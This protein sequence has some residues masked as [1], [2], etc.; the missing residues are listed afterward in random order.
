MKFG[1]IRA[2]L[3]DLDGTLIDSA[4]D[5]AWAADQL[6]L[7]RGLAPLPLAHYRPAVGS[8]A[9]GLIHAALGLGPEHPEF[10]DLKHAFFDTYQACMSQRTQAFEQV[11]EL[12]AALLQSGMAWA[13]VTNKIER[14]ALPLTAA[15]PLFASAS[16]VIGGDTTPHPKPH[17]A[18]LL[19]A[20]RRLGIAPQHCIYVGDDRRDIEAG[21]AAGMGTVAALY[22]YIGHADDPHTWGADAHIENPLDL[23]NF[24][25]DALY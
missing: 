20:A 24:L 8:G 2:V 15:L 23:L 3:F 5:L 17:P 19:E 1:G 25:G 6:R 12:V 7:A 16:T 4:P 18:P 21:R 14:F 9:R 10:D 13:V 22:G 11:N